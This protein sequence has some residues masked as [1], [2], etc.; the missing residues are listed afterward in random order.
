MTVVLNK[1][2]LVHGEKHAALRYGF[3]R[4]VASLTKDIQKD[5]ILFTSAKTGEGVDVMFNKMATR[6]V[7]KMN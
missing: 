5:G 1:L 6:L 3:K 2:D 4:S 7:Q